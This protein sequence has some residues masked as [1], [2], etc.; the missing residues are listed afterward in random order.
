MIN[1]HI[2]L[3]LIVEA[4][5]DTD[6]LIEEFKRDYYRNGKYDLKSQVPYLEELAD[7]YLQKYIA[8]Q[9]QDWTDCLKVLK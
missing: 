3:F 5:S 1:S 6:K 4:S 2:G 9:R 8:S 7:R